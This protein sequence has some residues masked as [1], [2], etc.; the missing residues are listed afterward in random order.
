MSVRP[1]KHVDLNFCPNFFL[2]DFIIWFLEYN[3]K[4]QCYKRSISI[5]K[6][7]VLFFILRPRDIKLYLIFSVKIS[8]NNNF[9]SNLNKSL[10]FISSTDYR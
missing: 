2:S 9:S 1:F 10:K 6:L 4:V 8:V 3:N 7:D 5:I